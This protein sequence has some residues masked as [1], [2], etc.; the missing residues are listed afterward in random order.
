MAWSVILIYS[1]EKCYKDFFNICTQVPNCTKF[2]SYR[3]NA[4]VKSLPE[5]EVFNSTSNDLTLIK[6]TLPTDK[7]TNITLTFTSIMGVRL[8]FRNILISKFY[9][10]M[11]VYV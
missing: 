6:F 7:K 9:I 1:T 11:Y 5:S 2:T 4:E 8:I 10:T 3:V